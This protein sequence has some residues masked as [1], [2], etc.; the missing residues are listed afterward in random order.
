MINRIRPLVLLLTVCWLLAG[1][2]EAIAAGTWPWP[3]A[4]DVI[5]P[6]KNTADP[7]AAGQHRGVDIAA[8]IG[9]PVRSTTAGHVRYAGKLPD[10]GLCVTIESADGRYL[11][12]YLHLAT[13]L[14]GRGER[15]T[16]GQ[17][18]GSAG[19][20]G[21]RSATQP[22]LHLSTRVSSSGAYVNPLGLLGPQPVQS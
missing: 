11:V 6:Y 9:T 10:G 20:T 13:T 14:A 22:H 2:G 3:V 15:V 12:S 18:I 5:T 8:V 19:T 21:K 17:I 16:A 7:Y 1:P 4:G